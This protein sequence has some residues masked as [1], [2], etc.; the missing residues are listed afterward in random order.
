MIHVTKK[1]EGDALEFLETKPKDK[2]FLLTVS[3]FATHAVD[4]NPKQYLPQPQSMELYKDIKIPIPVTAT[5]S[6]FKNYHHSF[7]MKKRRQKPMALAF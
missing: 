7:Q 1:N 5:E 4:G 2:P 3:F 6:H